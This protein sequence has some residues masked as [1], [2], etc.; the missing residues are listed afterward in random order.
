MGAEVIRIEPPG[1]DPLRG[2]TPHGMEHM[3]EGLNYLTEVRNKY[4]IT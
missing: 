1:G 2:F 3:G 4:H